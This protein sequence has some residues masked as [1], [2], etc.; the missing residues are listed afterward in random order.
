VYARSVATIGFLALATF[1]SVARA[2]AQEEPVT[3]SIRRASAAAVRPGSTM[4]L[5]VVAAIED[6]WHIYSVTQGPGGPAPT[7][8]MLPE[9]QPFV[10][11]GAIR[12]PAPHRAFDP[13]F[14][15][16]TEFHEESTA[17][18][19]PVRVAAEARAANHELT[20]RVR[21]QACTDTVCLPPATKI[22][23][24]AVGVRGSPT[25][26][27]PV[28]PPAAAVA[29][30]TVVRESMPR[31]P[32]PVASGSTADASLWAFL[33][34]A[35]VM[36]ALSLLTPC[37]FPMVPITVS[38]F[39]NHAAGHRRAAV[40]NALV[41]SAGIIFT[42]TAL[43][44]ALALVV[45]ASGMNLFAANPWIN[46]LITAI[47][48][49]FAFS[50]FGAYEIAVPSAI[51]TRLDS[52][53]PRTGGPSVTGT[54]LMGLT[55]TLTSFTCTA[56]F[57]GTL[58]VMAS[59]GDWQRPVVGMLAF[60]TIFALPFFVLALVPQLVSQLPRAG[61]WLNSVK[62][63][64]GFLEVA[65]A[66]KFISNVDLVWG[67]NIFT[68]DVVLASWIAIGVLLTLYLIGAFRVG[69]DA[70]VRRLGAVRLGAAMAS[71]ALSVYLTTGLFGSRLGEI[72]AFLPPAT[73]GS[74]GGRATGTIEGE[75]PW[76]VNDYD[77]ALSAAKREGKLVFVDFTGY[78][79]TNCRWMEA[80]MFPR[81]DVR[82]ELER[83]VRVRLY[84]DGEG[85]IY[86]RYQ[87]LQ[88]AMFKTVALPYYA[89]LSSDARPIATFP[90]LTRKPQEFLAFLQRSAMTV[91]GAS[92]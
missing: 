91:A 43:G 87:K 15:I 79:C 16:E 3:W 47:F 86:E 77:G 17:F 67:W 68:R 52:L 35:M 41:Y 11:D 90:G 70:A 22:L 65:A 57:V 71:L 42:F 48:L 40:T 74:A 63:S 9:R 49:G 56:P 73:D 18:E 23:T 24:L 61:G 28:A 10:R 13:N 36:G 69:R 30:P 64:M 38:Y 44:T 14:E 75:L 19:V 59:Q 60:S 25:A 6:G 92:E 53:S 50:L 55:F 46:L 84:T 29:P 72:E 27:P 5:R 58:F 26:T 34:L 66:M 32:T 81:P 20:V 1:V 88:S 85:E 51:L 8:I 80:N 89:I 33:S 4:T 31:A 39:T 54:L 21:F 78:T 7:S 82:R 62:V 76:I 45:G 37:V 12:A 83:Y 2:R